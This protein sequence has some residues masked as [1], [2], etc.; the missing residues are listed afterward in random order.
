MVDSD[1]QLEF[2]LGQMEA[3]VYVCTEPTTRAGM[4]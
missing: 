2:W 3:C 1:V 4:G